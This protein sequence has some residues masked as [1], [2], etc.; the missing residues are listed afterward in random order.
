MADAGA[1]V[2][3]TSCPMTLVLILS[4][5]GFAHPIPALTCSRL[6]MADFGNASAICRTKWNGLARPTVAASLVDL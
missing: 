4:G 3:P 6:S 2:F 5:S 1:M